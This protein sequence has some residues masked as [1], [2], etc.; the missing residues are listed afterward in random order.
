MAI[1]GQ[2]TPIIMIDKDEFNRLC[3]V[4][5]FLFLNTLKDHFIPITTI[6]VVIP[7]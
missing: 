5:E 7:K 1:K 2:A 6:R 3:H 4:M